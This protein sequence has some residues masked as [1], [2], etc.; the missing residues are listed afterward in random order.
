MDNLNGYGLNV[1]AGADA[2]DDEQFVNELR[3]GR[4][5]WSRAMRAMNRGYHARQP[6]TINLEGSGEIEVG[7][8]AI[9]RQF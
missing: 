1:N 8:G 7:K 3:E 2:D 5:G 9:I 6:R 4:S